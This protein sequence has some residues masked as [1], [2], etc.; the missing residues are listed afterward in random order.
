MHAIRLS[1]LE[2]RAAA[3]F[4]NIETRNRGGRIIVYRG[5]CLSSYA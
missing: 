1:I 4:E 2:K 3:K 5:K